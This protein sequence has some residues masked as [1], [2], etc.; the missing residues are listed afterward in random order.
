RNDLFAAEEHFAAV[1]GAQDAGHFLAACDS[2]LGLSLTY[3]ARGHTDLAR[4]TV[5]QA[6][7]RM[8]DTGN[9]TQLTATRA[10]EARLA[11][12]RG[13]LA[14]ATQWLRASGSDDSQ[15][16]P[17]RIG[18]P[19]LTRARVLVAQNTPQS[20]QLATRELAALAEECEQ[21]SDVPHLIE[22]LALQAVAY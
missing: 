7:Q 2:L 17:W 20:L 3:Q 21:R 12:L 1:V 14:A 9:E 19:R 22:V 5:E 11:C 4:S 16:L 18:V 10:F 15:M 6:S 13:D 8:L